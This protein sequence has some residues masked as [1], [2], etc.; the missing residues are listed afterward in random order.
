MFQYNCESVICEAT[1][2][3]L[4]F[5]PQ[6]KLGHTIQISVK[7]N[8]LTPNFYYVQEQ[9]ERIYTLAANAKVF[10]ISQFYCTFQNHFLQTL[11]PC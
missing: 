1:M 2:Y 4:Y 10:V 11:L 3:E 7:V 8:K 5:K 9:N 6:K